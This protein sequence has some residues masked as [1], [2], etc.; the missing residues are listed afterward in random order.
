MKEEHPNCTGSS[1]P[2][3]SPGPVSMTTEVLRQP[4]LIFNE[5][6]DKLG[7]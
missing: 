2:H 5:L 3:R 4:D 1:N 6:A 7:R